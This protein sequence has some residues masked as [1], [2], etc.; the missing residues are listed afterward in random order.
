MTT[1]RL[2]IVPKT[3][4][5]TI[6]IIFAMSRYGKLLA[7]VLDG[8]ADANISFAELCELVRRLGFDE[9]QRGSHHIFSKEGVAEIINL[10]PGTAG[11]AK[12]YQVKQVRLIIQQYGLGGAHDE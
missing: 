11:S 9:R 1:D 2:G 8:A 7:R 5:R 12:A 4:D 6:I 3:V 10:Q